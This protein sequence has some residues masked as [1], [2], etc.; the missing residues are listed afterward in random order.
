ME[1]ALYDK[2][3]ELQNE[4]WW[5]VARRSFIAS[6]FAKKSKSNAI[7]EIGCGPGPMINFLKNYGNFVIGIDYSEYALTL[8]TQNGHDNLVRGTVEHLPFSDESFDLL[9]SFEVLYHKQV[10]NDISVMK[11]MHRVCKVGGHVVIVD[12]AF[13][14][15]KGKHHN[16]SHG[17]RR[18]TVN[19]LTRKLESVGFVIKRASYIYMSIFPLLYVMRVIKNIFSPKNAMSSELNKT[20]PLVNRCMII[21]FQFE[22]LILRKLNFPFGASV[23]CM[24]EKVQRH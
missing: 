16:F 20:N 18:Y 14:F 15:L 24:A 11:E 6:F 7:L 21:L 17:I 12:P 5:F 9:T 19:E 4:H 3:S 22:A 1:K 2:V 13:D 8:C 10:G 23:F